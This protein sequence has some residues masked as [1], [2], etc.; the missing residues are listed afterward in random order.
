MVLYSD[1]LL[2]RP[3][4]QTDLED[5]FAI[6]G[7]PETNRFNPAGPFPNIQYAESVMAGW[8]KH[9]NEHGFGVWAIATQKEPEN[10]IGFGGLSLF[11]FE[12]KTMNNLGYRLSTA[13]W[14]K[15]YA[16]EFSKRALS[17][18]FVELGFEQI[19]ARVR[20][21]HLASIQVLKKSGFRNE[22][23][24]QDVMDAP[25]SLLFQISKTE[26]EASAAIA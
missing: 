14:G 17:F 3:V 15:G 19:S 26:W 25:A 5:L 16:T 2:M 21:N 4:C 13:S 23:K 6:Y 11:Q 8:L 22:K 9:W 7:D 10:V 24:I 20:E 1:R 18:G 12:G